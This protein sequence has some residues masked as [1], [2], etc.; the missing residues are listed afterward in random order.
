M[1][2]TW[3]T[4]AIA[5][6]PSVG[7]VT[8]TIGGQELQV[9]TYTPQDC[10]SP[11]ILMIFHGNSRSARSYLESAVP[12]ADRSCF[13][14]Y[15]PLFDKERFPN[16]S[17]HRG[18]LIHD[19]RLRPMEEWTVELADDLV[20][21]AQDDNGNPD[22]PVYLFGHSAGAQFLSR[23]AA[24]SLPD[25][26]QR[27]ILANPSTYVLPTDDEERPMAMAGCRMQSRRRNGC[28]LIWRPPSPSI[29]AMKIPGEKA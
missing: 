10:A 15:A 22:A 28:G 21:W 11:S 19:G 24:Y 9:F 8:A 18:G 17:Y 16:W 20:D 1:A 7:R 26:A 3:A 14:L 2:A 27:I 4:V 13:T 5:D 12:L 29:W 23:V 25:E 6:S